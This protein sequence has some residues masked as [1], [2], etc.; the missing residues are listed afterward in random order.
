M[1]Q[2]ILSSE[3]FLTVSSDTD[4][5]WLYADWHGQVNS[6]DVMTGSLLLLDLMRKSECNKL[7]NNNTNLSGIW[8]DAAIWGAEEILPQLYQAGCRYMAWVYSP[9][10][11]SRLSTKLVLEHATAAIVLETFDDLSTACEWLGKVGHPIADRI[12]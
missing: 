11:Y 10:T 2:R 1:P 4:N 6:E 3:V 9:E 8:A 7:L 5:N 12:R